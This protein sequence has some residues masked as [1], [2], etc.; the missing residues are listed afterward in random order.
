[1]DS[2]EIKWC[3]RCEN[4]DSK[5]TSAIH[6]T[7]RTLH[8]AKT[9]KAGMLYNVMLNVKCNKYREASGKLLL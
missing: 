1:M 7:K 2:N 8:V 5:D 9:C 6:T 4:F 3:E